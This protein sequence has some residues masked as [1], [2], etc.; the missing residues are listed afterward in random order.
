MLTLLRQQLHGMRPGNAPTE[1]LLMPLFKLTIVGFSSAHERIEQGLRHALNAD[2]IELV[3]FQIHP[4][5]NN[6][7]IGFNAVVRCH[8]AA[9]G[10]LCNLV[11]RVGLD[12]QVR[13]V[14]WESIPQP[15]YWLA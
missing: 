9:R 12:P 1:P 7:L 13:L 10:V 15:E 6:A 2:Q 5:I 8:V 11:Q 4:V 14:R 3:C